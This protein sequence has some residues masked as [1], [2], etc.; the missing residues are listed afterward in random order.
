MKLFPV[1]FSTAAG[2]ELLLWIKSVSYEIHG[3]S[4]LA[5]A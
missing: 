3:K 4:S 2:C 1:T 5:Q